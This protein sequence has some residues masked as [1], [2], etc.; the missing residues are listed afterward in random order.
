MLLIEIC[1]MCQTKLAE[2]WPLWSLS[3]Q[4]Q[5]AV[6]ALVEQTFISGFYSERRDVM[7]ETKTCNKTDKSSVPATSTMQG[8]ELCAPSVIWHLKYETNM[9]Y[10]CIPYVFGHADCNRV[11]KSQHQYPSCFSSPHKLI[12]TARELYLRMQILWSWQWLC[13]H[14]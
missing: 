7:Q 5:T 2:P 13:P 14:L 9:D 1:N 4:R 12:G 8:E 6:W 11:Q 3:C 10:G